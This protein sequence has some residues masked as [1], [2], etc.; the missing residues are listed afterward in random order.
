VLSQIS[1]IDPAGAGKRLTGL[2]VRALCDVTNPLLGPLGAARVFGPQKGAAPE[3]VERLE[4]GLANL[5]ERLKG[6][7]GADV[8]AMPGAGAAGGLGAAVA[9]FLGG[10]LVSGIDYVLDTLA[11]A[12]R[13]KGADL[14]ITGEGSFDSQSMGGKAVSGVLSRARSAGVPVAVVCG[15]SQQAGL[16]EL[17][18]YSGA[19]LPAE[20]R[21]VGLVG[22]DGLGYLAAKAVADAFDY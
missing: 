2:R 5:A 20:L 3:M 21:P 1:R 19:D 18:I 22:M 6:D 7:L 15:V 8:A 16:P 10:K 4:A 12:T 13:I 9:A 11:F 17:K 14:V